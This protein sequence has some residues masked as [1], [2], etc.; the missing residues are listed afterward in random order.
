MESIIQR[1]LDSERI[2]IN[3]RQVCIA[4]LTVA[5]SEICTIPLTFVVSD[6]I[7][8]KLLGSLLCFITAFILIGG[9]I[10]T[11][12]RKSP[13]IIRTIICILAYLLIP[14]IFVTSG[15]LYCG[16][17]TWFVFTGVC[18]YNVS[19][20]IFSK[21]FLCLYFI[22]DSVLIFLDAL[23]PN[24]FMHL[25]PLYWAIDAVCGL[26]LVTILVCFYMF[27][28]NRDYEK[29]CIALEKSNKELQ[30][31]LMEAREAEQKA[32]RDSLTGLFNRNYLESFME[33]ISSENI[34]Y[35]GVILL[36]IDNLK[37][38]N[39]S[40]GHIKGDECIQA[41]GNSIRSFV[42][43]NEG[44]CARNEGDEF[45][46]FYKET[47]R[48]SLGDNAENLCRLIKKSSYGKILNAEYPVTVSIGFAYAEEDQSFEELL[49]TA[50]ENL[51]MA[52]NTGRNKVYPKV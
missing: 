25:S 15:G 5:L 28:M 42:N 27:L 8:N 3:I 50:Q 22:E 14:G 24:L 35:S 16:M 1:L 4:A 47:K 10:V 43:V 12:R 40:C 45:L 18:L 13:A 9:V 52:K 29:K 31:A 11:I 19:S 33:K 37:K 44:F 48:R 32:E 2:P 17:L 46:I 36:D 39:D 38:I 51:S 21:I 41:V 7:V 20:R 34:Q 49:A 26:I 30:K 23:N 6:G